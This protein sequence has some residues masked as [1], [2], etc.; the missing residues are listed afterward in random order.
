MSKVART[1]IPFFFGWD[2]G[3]WNCDKN[4]E[5]R[6]ALMILDAERSI[7]GTPWRGNLRTTIN[8]SKTTRDWLKA[9]FAL[10]KA[11]GPIDHIHVTL[12]IDTP[13]GFSHAFAQLLIHGEFEEPIGQPKTN[14]YLFRETEHFL[15]KH[16]LHPSPP[17][18]T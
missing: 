8:E 11:E 18:R 16:G 4:P 3:G 13:L 10:C 6:D 17:S 7:V 1:A 9:L 5:S 15:F 12:A 14:P 2:V